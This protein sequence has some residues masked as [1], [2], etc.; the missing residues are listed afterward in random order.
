MSDPTRSVPP[1]RNTTGWL[2]YSVNG[3]TLAGKRGPG[4]SV[5]FETLQAARAAAAPV[6]RAGLEAVIVREDWQ[7]R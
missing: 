6:I 4:Q 7:A 5:R 1:M 2:L 3:R